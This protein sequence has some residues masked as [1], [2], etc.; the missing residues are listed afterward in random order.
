MCADDLRQT[1]QLPD[2]APGSPQGAGA[3]NAADGV[4]PDVQAGR[5]ARFHGGGSAMKWQR[6]RAGL[7]VSGQFT[8]KRLPLHRAVWSLHRWNYLVAHSGT[9]VGAKLVAEQ[10]AAKTA[11]GETR[12]DDSSNT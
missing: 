11:K 12:A 10:I 8:M 4:V 1:E 3:R 6:L 9:M 5:V 2:R 7:Y